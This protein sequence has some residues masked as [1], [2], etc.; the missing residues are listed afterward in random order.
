MCFL[1]QGT[2][3]NSFTP[4]KGFKTSN[5]PSRVHQIGLQAGGSDWVKRVSHSQTQLKSNHT[6][7][8]PRRPNDKMSGDWTD[9]FAA[10]DQ[11]IRE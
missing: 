8:S 5:V 6:S 10:T 9:E 2:P 4:E 1:D 3:K 7:P 11:P